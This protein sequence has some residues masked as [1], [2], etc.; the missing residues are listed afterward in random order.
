MNT[1]EPA[2]F[3]DCACHFTELGTLCKLLFLC[4]SEADGRMMTVLKIGNGDRIDKMRR[5]GEQHDCVI[6]VKSTWF[7]G[8]C[9]CILN[10]DV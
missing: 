6:N 2:G 8:C 3:I 7:N 10:T 9:L 1:G 4:Y 5:S